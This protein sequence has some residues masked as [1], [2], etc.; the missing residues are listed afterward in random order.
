MSWGERGSRT[1]RPERKARRPSPA[2]QES[3]PTRRAKR[4][5]ASVPLAP[6]STSA[7][8][9]DGTDPLVYVLVGA[10]AVALGAAT[11]GGWVRYRR[12]LPDP[13]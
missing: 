3:Q 10:G 7:D 2:Q 13:D 11:W 12:R 1:G 5:R 6:P 9:D 4:H 8:S